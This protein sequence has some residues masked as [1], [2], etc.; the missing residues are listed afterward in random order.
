MSLFEALPWYSSLSS[1]ILTFS[2]EYAREMGEDGL[3][4]LRVVT[5]PDQMLYCI[6]FKDAEKHFQP[7]VDMD[8]N[9]P[10]RIF[11]CGCKLYRIHLR[12]L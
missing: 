1:C 4:G 3:S 12:R 10:V 6:Y 5:N 8:S 7:L 9:L 11:R 2:N